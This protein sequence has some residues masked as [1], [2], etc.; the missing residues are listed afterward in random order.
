MTSIQSFL[1]TTLKMHEVFTHTYTHTLYNF[2][3]ASTKD[4]GN[5]SKLT[6][7]RPDSA[8]QNTKIDS[9]SK[10]YLLPISI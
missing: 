1:V 3:E 8:A 5:I 4:C 9:S 2:A 6:G 10:V 7:T